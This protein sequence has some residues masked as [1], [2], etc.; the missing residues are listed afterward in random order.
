MKRRQEGEMYQDKLDG[1]V[2]AD[3][4]FEHSITTTTLEHTSAGS[5]EGEDNEPG[6]AAP[7]VRAVGTFERTC[8]A[9]VRSEEFPQ[10]C[11][12]AILVILVIAM[13]MLP[14]ILGETMVNPSPGPNPH[15]TDSPCPLWIY[16]LFFE[17][18]PLVFQQSFIEAG[19]RCEE[20]K[21]SAAPDSVTDTRANANLYPGH[22][23][24]IL[25][26]S[27]SLWC[28]FVWCPPI[29]PPHK[30][31]G[32]LAWT[33]LLNIVP[34][35]LYASPHKTSLSAGGKKLDRYLG[36]YFAAQLMGNMLVTAFHL[37]N[38]TGSEFF[39]LVNALAFFCISGSSSSSSLTTTC[40]WMNCKT[41]R[42]SSCI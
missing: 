13:I 10:T 1:L 25:S 2:R 7:R 41:L 35:R 14:N 11:M 5:I 17:S 15:L 33:S 19:E 23:F 27:C 26:M 32:T 39:N 29:P 40:L 28:F 30:I 12:A 42:G 37:N 3:H 21:I 31:A 4:L 38:C 8:F 36:S 16:G 18:Y 20:R 34:R 6:A 22:L 9:Y 24:N